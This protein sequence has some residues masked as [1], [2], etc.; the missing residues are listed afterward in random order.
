MNEIQELYLSILGEIGYP[1]EGKSSFKKYLKKLMLENIKDIH[2]NRPKNQREPEQC[3]STRAAQSAIENAIDIGTI[4]NEYGVVIEAAKILRREILDNCHWQYLGMFDDFKIPM[5]LQTFCKTIIMGTRKIKTDQLT[6]AINMSSSILAQHIIQSCKTDRQTSYS[7]LKESSTF[8]CNVETP[9]SVDISLDFHSRT[10]S[11]DLVSKLKD[12]NIG[13]SYKK[14]MSIENCVA[15]SVI[16]ETKANDGVYLPPWTVQDNFTSFAIDNIDFLENTP[17]G[18]NT[19]HGTAIAMYQSQCKNAT[20]TER[21]FKRT[22]SETCYDDCELPLLPCNA[23]K[24]KKSIHKIDLHSSSPSINEKRKIDL[25][26]ILGSIDCQIVDEEDNDCKNKGVGTWSSFNSLCSSFNSDITNIALLAPLIRS[27]P[28]DINT[29]FTAIMRTKSVTHKVVGEGK[30]TVITFDMQLYD[31]AM[32]LWDVNDEIKKNF[33]FRPGELHVVFWALAA[34]G[35]YIEAS[36]IDQAWVEGGLFSPSTVTKLLNGK[37]LYRTLE[38]H[39][40]TFYQ[41]YFNKFLDIN[42]G[43]KSILCDI[44]KELR[45]S[46]EQSIKSSNDDLMADS[47]SNVMKVFESCNIFSK[48]LEF[49][50]SFTK[51]QMFI[52]QYLKQFETILSYIRATRERNFVLHLEATE[53]LIKYFFAHDHLSYA[54]LLPR[55]LSCMQNTQTNHPDIWQEFLNSNYCVTKSS[56]PFTSIAPDHALEQENRRVK[57]D[58]GITGITQNENALKRFFLIAPEIK[59]MSINFERNI[60]IYSTP[61]R[62]QHHEIHGNKFERLQNNKLKLQNVFCLHGDPFSASSDMSSIL[63]KAVL[64]DT[65][66]NDMLNRDQIGQELF[67]QFVM[68]RLLSGNFSV[69][70]QMKMKKLKT[71]QNQHFRCE[72]R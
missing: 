5:L 49:E 7:P 56:I 19:L 1:I 12:I 18:M 61:T 44:S 32:R 17:S 6:S 63:T 14:L 58:G 40:T 67:E 46:H 9:L 53:A 65:V 71:F 21:V 24:P 42:P 33:I 15:N 52:M 39:T 55:Y 20:N 10:R 57:V 45:N 2:F 22:N 41:L 62:T 48:I 11:K 51:Q 35:K 66:S 72:K 25:A 70:D 34:L 60:G 31:I 68:D 13:V 59:R 50:K 38:A 47:L 23:P 8:R 43:Y 16:E 37:Q 64:P 36:G 4:K 3:M 30:M 27:P 54:R 29:L 69:W 26:W 28:T